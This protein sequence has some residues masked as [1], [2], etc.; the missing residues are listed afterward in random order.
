MKHFIFFL[1]ILIQLSGIATARIDKDTLDITTYRR[2]DGALLNL[3]MSDEFSIDG[4]KFT[5]G[6]DEIF[7]SIDK[8]DDSNQGMH[9]CM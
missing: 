2:H 1:V 3:V 7:E 5:K 9:Y 8:P 6:E 4:R